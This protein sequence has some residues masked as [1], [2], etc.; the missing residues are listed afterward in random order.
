MTFNPFR[1][2]GGL[3]LIFLTLAPIC[4][5]GE[6]TMTEAQVKAAYIYNFSIYVDWPDGTFGS[7]DDPMIV[8]V[9]GDEQM[10]D[11]L[12]SGLKGKK[13]K[14]RAFVVK[15]S[16]S[17]ADL[18]LCQITYVAPNSSK[19]QEKTLRDFSLSTAHTLTVGDEP[20]AAEQGAVI[21]FF[22]EGK[23]IRFEVNLADARREGFNISYKLLQLAR[24]V[25]PQGV[26]K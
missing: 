5:A 25:G 12:G 26:G 9:L 24:I 18:K 20:G 2:P 23:R 22:Q 11:I 8:C 21:N 1:L 14:G 17:S 7:A 10:A 15:S 6:N 3:A 13:S 4:F 19:N 16:A